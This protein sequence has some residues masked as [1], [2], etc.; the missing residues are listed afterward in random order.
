MMLDDIIALAHKTL[1]LE[2]HEF[3]KTKGSTDTNLYYISSGS[4]RIFLEDEGQIIRLGYQGNLILALDSFLSQ[5]SSALCI[6]AIKKS[7][8]KVI[9]KSQIEAFLSQNHQHQMAWTKILEDLLQ[10]QMEREIDLLTP[11][12]A[13]RYL[14]VL[15][16]SPRLFQEIPNKYI[17]NYLRMS[18]ETLSRLKKS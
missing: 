13:E 5:K 4:L 18:P 3:L 1:S 11:S 14:R 10:Q 2:R 7:L 15:K 8:V 16:R 17:A 12:P 9:A 6:Q